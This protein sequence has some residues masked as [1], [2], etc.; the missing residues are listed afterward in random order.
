MSK[1]LEILDVACESLQRKGVNGFSFRDLADAV[2]VKSSSVHYHFANKTDL[3][4]EI[5]LH[6]QEIVSKHLESVDEQSTSLKQCL[7]S[8]ID[9]FESSLKED[10]FCVCGMLAVDRQHLAPEVIEVLQGS[11]QGLEAWLLQV[12]GKYPA[13]KISSESLT[14]LLI[15][16]CE[17]ALLLDRAS[18]GQKHLDALRVTIE[19]L[20]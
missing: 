4:T 9:I 14:H 15:A 16:S 5:V 3:F 20:I 2:G 18:G 7:F 10:K 8:F 12:M 17:G 6:F 19:A 1:K 11:F 13:T